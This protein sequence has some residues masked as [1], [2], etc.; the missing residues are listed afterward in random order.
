MTVQMQHK[1]TLSYSIVS[2]IGIEGLVTLKEWSHL[3]DHIFFSYSLSK[4]RTFPAFQTKR[5]L[6][7]ADQKKA[8]LQQGMH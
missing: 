8:C 3:F 6:F 7:T 2:K 4:S 5:H 1:F